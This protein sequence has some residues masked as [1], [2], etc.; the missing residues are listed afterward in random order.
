MHWEKTRVLVTGSAGVIGKALVQQLANAG[1]HI[2]S[3]DIAENPFQSDTITHI[4]ADL[5][6]EI[7]A[8]L[9][10]FDPHVVFHLAATFERTVEETGYW[11][12]SFDNNALL[13]HM[14]LRRMLECPALN[15]FI[16][17]S[18]YLIYNPAQYI[19]VPDV[20]PLRETD[21]IAP[22][23]LVGTAKYLTE[24]ELE[25]VQQTEKKLRVVSARIFRV[26]GCG[27][28]DVISRWV[29]AALHGTP[30]EVY[31]QQN[32]FDYIYADDVAA[33]LLKLAESERASGVV[34]LGS[35]VSRSISDV[36]AAL[37]HEF[38]TLH[39][40][41]ASV[42]ASHVEASGADMSWFET[43]TGWRPAVSLEEGIRRIVAY[44]K[45][46]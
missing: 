33:G 17:A 38:P 41:E 14:L 22:R 37:R 28:R 5:A 2:L 7:P 13:S 45:Q 19:D 20:K 24:R 15:A 34:N 42:A 1:A 36:I 12:T 11:K 16:F 29:R 32:R 39:I 35:G 44:E 9:V 25:F 26:Y 27:S 4:Q 10:T 46:S 6:R 40:N 31:G 3:V 21:P 30:L 23:N 8:A 18:S 43:L